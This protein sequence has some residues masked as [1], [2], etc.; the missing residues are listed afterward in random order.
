M[1]WWQAILAT[2]A[3]KVVDLF[4]KVVDKIGGKKKEE[5]DSSDNQS[6]KEDE[7]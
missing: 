3:P 7:K 6:S 1:T 4:G 2:I 5:K